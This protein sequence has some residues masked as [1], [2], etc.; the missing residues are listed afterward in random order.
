MF[1]W[2]SSHWWKHA[3]LN[4]FIFANSFTFRIEMALNQQRR[5]LN[6]KHW[7]FILLLKWFTFGIIS[8]GFPFSNICIGAVKNS[9][10]RRLQ[11]G[12]LILI[13]HLKCKSN[14]RSSKTN[15][16]HSWAN[17]MDKR[18]FLISNISK[19]FSLCTRRS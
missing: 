15:Y 14:I 12:I 2:P 10:R 3:I 16:N 6:C 5:Y 17:Q 13:F 18:C 19:I 11:L 4:A 8:I 7:C 9:P 1:K